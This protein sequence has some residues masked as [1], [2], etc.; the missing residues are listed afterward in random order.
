VQRSLTGYIGSL[1]AIATLCSLP[2]AGSIPQDSDGVRYKYIATMRKFLKAIYPEAMDH[3]YLMAISMTGVFDHEWNGLP[4]LFVEIGLNAGLRESPRAKAPEDP[5]LLASFAFDPSGGLDTVHVGSPNGRLEV[6]RT[7]VSR[8]INAHPEWCDERVA[9]E[10]KHA[11][12]KFGPSER[13]AL[14]AAVPSKVLEPFIGS[15][16]VESAEF[17]LRHHQKPEPIAELYWVVE[18]S[19]TMSNGEKANWEMGFDAFEGKL[20]DLSRSPDG[21]NRP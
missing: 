3:H 7:E 1:I 20:T 8:I 21:H 16:T 11:G 12:A 18:A 2:L 5:F 15:M 17:R 13:S 19:S 10:L 9:T 14:I 6:K 4:T